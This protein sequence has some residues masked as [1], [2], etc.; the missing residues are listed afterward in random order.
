[1]VSRMRSTDYGWEN[2]PNVRLVTRDMDAPMSV[3]NFEGSILSVKFAFRD[4]EED[5]KT[6]KIYETLGETVH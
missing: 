1:M 6:S 5:V 2:R 3:W 4:R